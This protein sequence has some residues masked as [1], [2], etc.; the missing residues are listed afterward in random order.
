L[1]TA[2]TTFLI[3]LT[4]TDSFPVTQFMSHDLITSFLFTETFNSVTGMTHLGL[5]DSYFTTTFSNELLTLIVNTTQNTCFDLK[6]YSYDR[7]Y[8]S[9]FVITPEDGLEI[10]GDYIQKKASLMGLVENDFDLFPSRPSDFEV[11]PEAA[12]N[13]T[14][15][16]TLRGKTTDVS[17]LSSHELVNFL[18]NLP[19]DK[20]DEYLNLECIR[21]QSQ[22]STPT[23]KLHYPE[24][25]IA[26][27]SF[28]HTDIAFI[29]ILH[30]NY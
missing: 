21:A 23:R 5:Q 11:Q 2:P 8:P 16:L 17:K 26:S 4:P 19:Q 1:N 22:A 12:I 9:L 14:N 30:Y 6:I 10:F 28:I 24:P 20:M 27:A 25:F 18:Y 15:L 29:H 7:D 13:T 3:F